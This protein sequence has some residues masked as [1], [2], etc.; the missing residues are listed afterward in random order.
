MSRRKAIRP[1]RPPPQ[2][3]LLTRAQR[4]T[5]RRSPRFAPTCWKAR[6]RPLTVA[7]LFAQETTSDSAVTYFV[8][9]AV[10][11]APTAVGEGGEYPK[12]EFGDPTPKTDALKKIGCIYKDTDEL[13]A[14]AE[15]LAQSIDNRAEYLLDITV[16]DQLLTGNGTGNN[17]EGLLNRAAFRPQPAPA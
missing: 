2:S 12:L 4:A 9:G 16:E 13:L 14:D 6:A 10:T 5:L 15:R 11:G 3:I 8:E 17:I 1:P 7:D